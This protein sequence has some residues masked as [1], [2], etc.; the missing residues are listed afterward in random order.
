MLAV[1]VIYVLYCLMSFTYYLQDKH[2]YHSLYKQ[3]L[4]YWIY[5]F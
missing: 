5:L 2:A 1:A 3:F 4:K